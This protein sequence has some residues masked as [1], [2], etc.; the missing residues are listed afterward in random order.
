MIKLAT[1]LAEKEV[2][3]GLEV[4]PKFKE[5]FRAALRQYGYS[6]AS[7]D[8]LSI[9]GNKHGRYSIFHLVEGPNQDGSVYDQMLGKVT[10]KDLGGMERFFERRLLQSMEINP[11]RPVVALDLG[12]VWGYSWARLAY[13]FRDEVKQGRMAFV[14]SNL[15][16]EQDEAATKRSELYFDQTQRWYL[17]EGR[18]HMHY[19]N[20]EPQVL[21]RSSIV[22]ANGE[23]IPLKG[24]VDLMYERFSMTFWSE[25]PDFEIPRAASLLSPS[26]LYV[27]KTETYVSG[28]TWQKERMVAVS[29]GRQNAEAMFGL[30]Q[31]LCVEA[32]DLCGKPFADEHDVFRM[33]EAPLIEVNKGKL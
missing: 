24:N 16:L 2:Y 32:G 25:I 31:I 17:R 21:S 8:K 15:N 18:K 6:F 22:L 23:R 7:D 26:G 19:I 27:S 5:R 20:G 3:G 9:Y 28:G 29:L 12:G 11:N 4:A 10:V 33:P 1:M 30:R 14:V 13:R